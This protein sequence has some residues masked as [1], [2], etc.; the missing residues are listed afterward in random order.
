MLGCKCKFS[1][2]LFV[3]YFHDKKVL[4]VLLV[5]YSCLIRMDETNYIYNGKFEENILTVGRTGCVK[6]IF[7][8]NLRKN[9]LF[10]NI[11][12]VYW[13]SKIEL[14][15]DR[16]ENIRDYFVDQVVNFGYPDNVEEF[17]DLLEIC[18]RKKADYIED[19]LWEKQILNKLIPMDDVFGLVDRSDKFTNFLTVL[20]KYRLTCIYIFHTI[21]LTRQN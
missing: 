15:R 18:Q 1:N 19:D 11:K 6:T 8:Q 21:H 17:N 12:E 13:I 2:N 14:S 3:N 20:R 9:K 7:V 4:V 16:D 10:D 5:P